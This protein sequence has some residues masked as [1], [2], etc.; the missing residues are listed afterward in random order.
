MLR[1]KIISLFLALL[2]TLQML[3]IAQIGSMLSNNQWTEELPHS[4][5]DSGKADQAKFSSTLPPEQYYLTSGSLNIELKIRVH[6][7][8]AIPTNHSTDI[9]TPP[10][11]VR[12]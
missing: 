1:I 3:P 8:E 11:D 10:P 6:I 12:A 4:H 2:M 9:V 5:D 7:P